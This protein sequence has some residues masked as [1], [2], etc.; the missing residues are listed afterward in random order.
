MKNNIA[1]IGL[2]VMGQNLARNLANH[3]YKVIVFNR[4]PE[5]A[6]TFIETFGSEDLS[7]EKT[8][9]AL[10]NS[11]ERPRKLLL[12]V[13][14]GPA[15]DTVIQQLLPH[16]EPGDI[17]ID[18]G[19]SNFKDSI[20]REK[21]LKTKDMHFVGM[22]VSGGEE[23]ALNGPSLMPGGSSD[24]WKALQAILEK[25]AAQ[26]FD[27]NPCVTHVGENGAGHYVK[28]VHNGIEYGVMQLIAEAYQLL[29][30]SYHLNSKEIANVFK[31]LGEG[32]LK[33][34]LFDIA[35]PVLEKEDE[36]KTCN[37]LVECIV[38]QAGQKGTGRWTAIDALERGVSL[39]TITIAVFARNISAKKELRIELSEENP[40]HETTPRIELSEF[41]KILE[42]S[43]YA[44]MISCYAQGFELM[45]TAAK[46][47]GWDLNF[48][49]I[50]RIWQGGCIIRA[51]LLKV[52]H[53]AFQKA[54][55][56]RPHL[57]SIPDIQT[58]LKSS[59]KAWHTVIRLAIEHDVSV[60]A[61][62]SSLMYFEDLT[63]ATLPAN[64]IQGL[65]DYF[66]A[67]TYQRTDREGVFHTEWEG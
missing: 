46:E 64:F 63:T 44:G 33:S 49:E 19:N 36:F 15:V 55:G 31:G 1:I 26:D 32:K 30:Q 45:K 66:G 47:E 29:R 51:D 67:H 39:P 10:V 62:S 34:Y 35:V 37:S 59:H 43:L 57:F 54:E 38:D 5:K 2:G 52:L 22:G 6:E 58:L 8:L 42:K 56:E 60:P 50:A 18:G 41:V 53:H 40:K 9:E 48:A 23:G 65:R 16:L 12:M 21:E 3:D 27:G 17:I 24:S 13:K 14:A 61:L 25:I 28:M 11:L 7:Y 20:R 4:S